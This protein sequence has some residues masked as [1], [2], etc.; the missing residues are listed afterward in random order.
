MLRPASRDSFEF[1]TEH[2]SKV[3]RKM[4]DFHIDLSPLYPDGGD[5]IKGVAYMPPLADSAEFA[6]EFARAAARASEGNYDIADYEDDYGDDEDDTIEGD[7][8]EDGTPQLSTRLDQPSEKPREKP[9]EKRRKSHIEAS[10]LDEP[11]L[12]DEAVAYDDPDWDAEESEDAA[13]LDGAPADAVVGAVISDDF[14][15]NL[16]D[17]VVDEYP[18]EDID[19]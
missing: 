1:R 11:D 6:G 4:E 17:S 15:E 5:E 9:W 8:I 16:D 7:T 12:E 19:A 13:R 14:Y 18:E 10:D 3:T 2:F